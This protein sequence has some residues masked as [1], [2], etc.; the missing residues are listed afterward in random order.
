MN[1]LPPQGDVRELAEGKKFL[2]SVVMPVY[3]E[4]DTIE[5]IIRRVLVL[6]VDI[7]IVIVDDGSKDGTREYLRKLS[8]S[9]IRIFFQEKNQGKGAAVR[10]GIAEA[11]G[12][13]IVIQDA[14]L[15]YHP[16]EFYEMLQPILDGRADAVYGSRFR[17]HMIRVH[18]FWHALGNRMLT[19]MSNMFTN[20]TLTDMEVCYKMF[21]SQV[22]KNVKLR[23]NGFGFEPEVTAKLAR[24]GCRIYEMPI[25]Y[26]GRDYKE[27]KKIGWKDAVTAFICII[28]YRFFD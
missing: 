17:G 13:V 14:D 24:M 23:S 12:D 6:E 26:D 3:N 18:Y 2:L 20:L 21:R 9:R 8:D 1:P 7:E 16:S 28:R 27:G 15:E 25:S 10:K 5:E 4:I 11:A 19:L 22:I